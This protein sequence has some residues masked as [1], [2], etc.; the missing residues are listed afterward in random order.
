MKFIRFF[1]I[2][3]MMLFCGISAWAENSEKSAKSPV[4]QISGSVYTFPVTLEGDYVLHDYIVKN[5]GNAGLKIIRV[6]ST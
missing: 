6:T 5:K 3:V 1:I 4:I 2:T